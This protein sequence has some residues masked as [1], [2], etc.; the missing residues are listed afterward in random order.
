MSPAPLPAAKPRPARPT[1]RALS[2]FAG[3]NAHDEVVRDA[4][5]ARPHLTLP[6]P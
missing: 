4:F 5:R 1:F 2:R 6:R 3:A